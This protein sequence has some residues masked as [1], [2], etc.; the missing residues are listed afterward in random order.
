MKA[1]APAGF[2]SS[3]KSQSW[4][5]DQISS[6]VET[7][8]QAL[9]SVGAGDSLDHVCLK[10]AMWKL[11]SVGNVPVIVLRPRGCWGNS[12]GGGFPDH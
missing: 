2:Q 4:L 8:L 1:I 6:S 9:V 5:Q 12:P 7:L 3:W 11:A 10:M